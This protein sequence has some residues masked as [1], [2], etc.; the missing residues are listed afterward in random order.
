MRNGQTAAPPVGASGGGVGQPFCPPA[1]VPLRPLAEGGAVESRPSPEAPP[2]PN[3]ETGGV[4]SSASFPCPSSQFLRAAGEP[5]QCSPPETR[6]ISSI[7]TSPRSTSTRALAWSV[8]IPSPVAISRI[9]SS[10]IS[11]P[12]PTIAAW[13]AGLK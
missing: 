12:D 11:S 5:P 13:M 10:L 8:S 9:S 3:G 2:R 4:A 7:E 1:L 6:S